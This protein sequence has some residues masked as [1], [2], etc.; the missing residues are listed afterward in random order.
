MLRR[1]NTR[2]SG[3]GLELHRCNRT[4]G[5]CAGICR[6]CLGSRRFRG[7]V[8]AALHLPSRI[9]ENVLPGDARRRS[10]GGTLRAMEA[11]TVWRRRIGALT[12]R[13]IGLLLEAQRDLIACQVRAWRTPVAELLDLET[14]PSEQQPVRLQDIQ[15]VGWAVTRAAVYGV[16]R[17]KC[18]VR[19]LAIQRMLRR[20]GIPGGRLAVGVQE[21]GRASCRERVWTAGVDGAVE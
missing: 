10:D 11:L 13:D 7:W 8:R 9:S 14:T 18:L 3:D 21:I 4:L 17:P 6:N 1:R 12:A 16:F 5:R 2:A 20:R 15:E 19:S